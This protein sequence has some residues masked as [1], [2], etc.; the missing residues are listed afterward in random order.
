[1][2]FLTEWIYWIEEVGYRGRK[3]S[4]LDRRCMDDW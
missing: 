3:E 1:M 2:G 4:L